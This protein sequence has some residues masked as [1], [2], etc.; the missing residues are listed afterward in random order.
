MKKLRFAAFFVDFC[1][2]CS[3]TEFVD[4][5]MVLKQQ[6]KKQNMRGEK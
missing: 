2:Q 5:A 1:E 4:A 3:Y 6:N